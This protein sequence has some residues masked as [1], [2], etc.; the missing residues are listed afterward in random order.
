MIEEAWT[1]KNLTSPRIRY[2]SKGRMGRAHYRTSMVT[3]RLREMSDKEERR[4]NRLR[5]AA[6]ERKALVDPRGY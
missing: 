4:L 3:V 6:A 2:H 5:K 1:G